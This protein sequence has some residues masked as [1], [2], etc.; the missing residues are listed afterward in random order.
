MDASKEPEEGLVL[1][2]LVNHGNKVLRNSHM[3]MIQIDSTP[4]L[5]LFALRNI[6]AGEE[7][8]YDYGIAE[9]ELPW[10]KKVKL[11]HVCIISDTG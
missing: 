2:R 6:V 9:K 1:G 5:C 10:N 3:K 4:T 7:I 8:L 11:I